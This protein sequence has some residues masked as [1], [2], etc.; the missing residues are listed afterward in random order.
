MC[1]ETVLCSDLSKV[2]FLSI[3]WLGAGSEGLK[4]GALNIRTIRV[5]TS[6]S[7]SLA[8][9]TPFF[10]YTFTNEAEISSAIK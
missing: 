8:W 1:A 3:I 9:G 10:S 5:Q 7:S 6:S 2:R 4:D